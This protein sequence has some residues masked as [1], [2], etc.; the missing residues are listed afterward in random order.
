MS[1]I[2]T[3]NDDDDDDN[4]SNNNNDNNSN[5]IMYVLHFFQNPWEIIVKELLFAKGTGKRL[6]IPRKMNNFTRIFQ[7]FHK[8]SRETIL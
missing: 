7:R 5:K 6:T 1:Q 4:N 8:K 2:K 3:V